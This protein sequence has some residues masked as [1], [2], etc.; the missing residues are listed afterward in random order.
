MAGK[1]SVLNK[2]KEGV[3]IGKIVNE[4][5]VSG[6]GDYSAVPPPS[7]V[8]P[9][10]LI[11]PKE[12][13]VGPDSYS[14]RNKENATISTFKLNG[15]GRYELICVEDEPAAKD[16]QQVA[17]EH[18]QELEDELLGLAKKGDSVLDE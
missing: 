7:S 12:V 14:V 6:R 13:R 9:K 11:K 8:L 18:E 5:E 10:D 2:H 4:N 15:D 17:E 1:S 16:E 3:R